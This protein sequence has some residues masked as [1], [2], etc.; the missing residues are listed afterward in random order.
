MNPERFWSLVRMRSR[1]LLRRGRVETELEKELRFHLEQEAEANLATGMAPAEAR[2]AALRRL[3][4]CGT[5]Q[6]GLRA[7]HPIP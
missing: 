7:T 1:S 5:D 2:Y 3:G 4:G 6:G